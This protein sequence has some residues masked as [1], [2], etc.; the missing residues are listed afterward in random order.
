L[1]ALA[2]LTSGAEA[3]LGW[4]VLTLLISPLGLVYYLQGRKR[5]VHDTGENEDSDGKLQER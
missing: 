3:L 4:R 2:G 1:F 5:F